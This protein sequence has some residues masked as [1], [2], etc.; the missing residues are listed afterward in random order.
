MNGGGK[1]VILMGLN[2]GEK[3]TA[4]LPVS[5]AG[6]IVTGQGRSTVRQKTL[7]K[8]EWLEFF[9]RR[10]RKGKVLAIRFTATGLAPLSKKDDGAVAEEEDP[11][12]KLF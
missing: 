12:P 11:E 6:C 9:G 2:D 4:V 3:L 5:D 10:A 7:V 8:N 1:G